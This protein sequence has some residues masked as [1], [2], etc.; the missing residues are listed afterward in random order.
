MR[1]C[2]SRSRDGAGFNA[3]LIQQL[4]LHFSK[5]FLALLASVGDLP[6]LVVFGHV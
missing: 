1:L 6:G 2:Q 4:L 3:G 5:M